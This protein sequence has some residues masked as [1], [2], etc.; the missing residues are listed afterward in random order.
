MARAKFFRFVE[1]FENA[2]NEAKYGTQP[3]DLTDDDLD[4][5]YD[6]GNARRPS[7]RTKEQAI[8]AIKKTNRYKW[9]EYKRNYRW[10]QKQMQ[11]LGLNPEDA[12]YLL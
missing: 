2:L 12:R 8:A 9:Y 1:E 10:V 3:R 11:R 5:W 6:A 7:I 4:D